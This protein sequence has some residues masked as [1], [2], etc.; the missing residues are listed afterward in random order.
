MEILYCFHNSWLCAVK[1]Q[2]L[3]VRS[4]SDSTQMKGNLKIFELTASYKY[5]E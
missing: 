2:K 3:I 4:I 1:H 5:S